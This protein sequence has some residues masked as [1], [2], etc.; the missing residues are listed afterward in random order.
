MRSADSRTLPLWGLALS[1]GLVILISLA[2]CATVAPAADATPPAAAPIAAPADRAAAPAA[3]PLQVAVSAETQRHFE[4]A[5]QAQRAGRSDE[6]ERVLRALA[7]EHP[8]LAG[9]HANLGLLHRQAGRHADAVA[10]LELAVNADP[11]QA[12]LQNELGIAY[13]MHGQFAKA[14]AAYERAIALDPDHAAA[15]LNLGILHDL[16]LGNGAKALELYERYLVLAP[17]GDASVTK[18]AADLRNRKPVPLALNTQPAEAP[19]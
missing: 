11:T 4:R 7:Q 8:G 18:W 10:A 12:R 14:Q 17:A 1:A 6:A 16:Y 15:L 5:L 19:R 9:V 3:A 2:G 13:R